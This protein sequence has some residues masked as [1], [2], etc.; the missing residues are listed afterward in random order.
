MESDRTAPAKQRHSGTRIHQRLV[1]EHGFVGSAAT[2]R[3]CVRRLSQKDRVQ[4][5]PLVLSFEAGQEGQ[6][7]W[8]EA[9]VIENGVETTV[10]LFEMRLPYSKASFVRAYRRMTL[11][12]FLDGHVRAF[13]FF[14]CVPRRLAYDNLRAAVVQINGRERKL[15]QAFLQLRSHYL[16]ESRFCNVACGNEK[17]DVENLVKRSKAAYLTPVPRC[18]RPGGGP[19][20]CCWRVAG[21]T[22]PGWIGARRRRASSC[23][24]KR[25]HGCWR[26]RRT[27]SWPACSGWA[28]PASRR[29]CG[30]RTTTTR[31]PRNWR[32]GRAWCGRSPARWRSCAST[33]RWRVMCGATGVG[34]HILEPEHYLRVLERKP[35][36]LDDALAFK[37][38][39]KDEDLQLLRRELRYRHGESGDKQFI[40]ILMLRRG[41]DAESFANAVAQCVRR[42]LFSVD[43]VGQAVKIRGLSA[44]GDAAGPFAAAG[45]APGD[46][47]AAGGGGVWPASGRRRGGWRQGGGV[48]PGGGVLMSKTPEESAVLGEFLRELKLPTMK[49]Q[50]AKLARECGEQGVGYERYLEQLCRMEVENRQNSAIQ[51][52]LREGSFPLNKEL[53]EFNFE[54]VP[55]LN[56]MRVTELFSCRFLQGRGNVV[57]VGPPGTGKTHLAIALGREACR[58]GCHVRF[59]TAAELARTYLDADEHRAVMKLERALKRMSL[60]VV[61]ELGYLPLGKEGSEHL[62]G[63]FSQCYER[64][65]L[66]ITTNLPFANWTATFGG[67]ERLTGA[68]LDRLT[69]RVTI[70]EMEGESYRLRQSLRSREGGQGGKTK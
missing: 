42:R 59:F 34:Q 49:Q 64:V 61:D 18:E 40:A 37:S 62:F 4:E 69:H 41:H 50:Y 22:W 21:A 63:F 67:D 46:Q 7:D 12:S 11:E 13:E 35:G 28:V 70:L 6:V 19:R 29:W 45:V 23:S 43:A 32:A 15:T 44:G 54:A 65:S 52:R 31:C 36:A 9:Q 68:L 51:R 16:F 10:Y 20:R 25:G 5:V 3:R 17:G 53:S 27:A 2:V 1:E 26:C 58:R 14:G 60:I 33:R 48:G 57:M 38:L 39:L 30:S 56:R 55:S 66:A 24:A 47:R 8:G